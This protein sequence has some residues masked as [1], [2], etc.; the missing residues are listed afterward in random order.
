M[1][2]I[3][4]EG[5]W[6]GGVDTAAAARICDGI[7]SCAYVTA[8]DRIAPLM[9]ETRALLGPDKTLIAG[10]LLSHPQV[11]DAADLADRVAAAAPH[12][13]GLNFY[14]LGLVPPAR[15]RWISKALQGLA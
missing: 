3:D 5:S 1:L 10:F 9:A 7:L 8:Q 15:L 13:D 12:V 4:A 2:L 14:N 11:A 6:T